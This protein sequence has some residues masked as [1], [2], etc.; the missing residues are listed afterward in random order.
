MIAKVHLSIGDV[1][2]VLRQEFPDVTI[3]KIRFLETQGLVTPQRTA[4]GLRKFS[5]SDVDRLQW[6]LQQ[7]RDHFYPLKV[8]K[9]KIAAM[10]P[11][12]PQSNGAKTPPTDEQRAAALAR[13]STVVAALQEGPR[14]A[15]ASAALLNGAGSDDSDAGE[16][17][18]SAK[19]MASLAELCSLSGLSELEVTQA[20]A[21]GLFASVKVAG[22]VVYAEDAIAVAK[23]VGQFRRYGM[24]PRHL[25]P[26]ANAIDR[27]MDLVGQVVNPLLRART[28]EAR[29]RAAEHA[30][31]MA[32]LGQSLRAALLRRALSKLLGS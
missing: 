28:P 3:S 24:E 7:Q 11:P 10:F 21:V 12:Q 15:A 20:E 1:L 31:E 18:G 25:R 4:S 17:V 6:I 16:V 8:I 2:S 5:K 26:Y 9:E 29:Q 22:E 27:E 30:A 23:L 19:T 32:K 14:E 13:V